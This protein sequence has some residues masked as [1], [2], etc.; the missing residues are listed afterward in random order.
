METPESKKEILEKILGNGGI[1]DRVVDFSPELL[2]FRPDVED[3]WTIRENIA[4]AVD[5]EMS[6]FLRIRQAVAN[7][8]S[9]APQPYSLEDW[10]DRFDHTVQSMTDAIQIYKMVHALAYNVLSNMEDQDWDTFTIIH[11]ARGK[12]T[13]Q[14][15]AKIISFHG[16][17]H[18]E[19]I[20]RNESLWNER[21]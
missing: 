12:Q 16:D 11:Y 7:P 20:E 2:D 8:G 15:I 4:H 17:F 1:F 5:S 18:L 19:L 13:L 3:A 6:L 10:K 14:D 9:D 21:Q